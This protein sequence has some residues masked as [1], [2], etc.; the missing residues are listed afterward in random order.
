[1]SKVN[2]VVFVVEEKAGDKISEVSEQVAEAGMEVIMHLPR[3]GV[4]IGNAHKDVLYGI[5]QVAGVESI[6]TEDE[7]RSALN[8]KAEPANHQ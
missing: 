4:I 5:S 7:F 3:A 8:S 1:M 2:F 6:L